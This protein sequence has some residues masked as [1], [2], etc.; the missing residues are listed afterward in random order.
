MENH[1]IRCVK[2]F[3]HTVEPSATVEPSSSTEAEVT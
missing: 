3:W 1:W 2:T